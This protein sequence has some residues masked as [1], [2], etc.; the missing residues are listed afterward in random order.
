MPWTKPDDIVFAPKNPLAG[1][2]KI[3]NAGIAAVMADGR[4]V[5]LPKTITAAQLKALVTHQG[6]EPANQSLLKR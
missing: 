1:L 3:S 4:M 2:G 6:G 5:T